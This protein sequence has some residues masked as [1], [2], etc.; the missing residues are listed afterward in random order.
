M[1]DDLNARRGVA[2]LPVLAL[3]GA[4]AAPFPA[5]AAASR[6][7]LDERLAR[8]ERMV[9]SQALAEIAG[10][11]AALEAELRTLRGSVEELQFALDGARQ[12]QRD[13]YLDLDRR[14]Q[15]VEAAT[16]QL[17]QA[18]VAAGPDPQAEYQAS[19]DL[20]K[21]G[22]YAEA[23]RGFEGFLAAHPQHDLA[24]NAQYWLAEVH[25]VERNYE[26]ALLAFERV[27]TAYPQARKASDALLKAGYCQYE[28]KRYAI[29]RATLA[30]VTREFPGTPA[31]RDAAQRLDR[32]AAEGR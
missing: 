13:Q 5:G 17:A 2:L 9:E 16:Q 12:Q 3:A 28:M 14:L 22:R 10:Q 30:R 1:R 4:L 24:A 11:L 21:E 29:A 18:T 19:F 8:V 23:Q 27:L 31:A 32:M 6:S 25:Y 15:A 7:E 20:L 26:G